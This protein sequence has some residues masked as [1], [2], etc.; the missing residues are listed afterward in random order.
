MPPGLYQIDA[1][2]YLP[3]ATFVA[4]DL[5]TQLTSQSY[6]V[7]VGQWFR[8][9][10]SGEDYP[11][12]VTW[13]C[14]ES[15][16]GDPGNEEYWGKVQQDMGEDQYETLREQAG[17]YVEFLIHLTP[18]TQEPPFPGF[19][20]IGCLQWSGRLLDKCPYGLYSEEII[21]DLC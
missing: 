7:P 3:S 4:Q 11:N 14:L 13:E 2:S 21:S 16:D 19:N 18:L 20:S 8:E 10:R 12:W 6:F 15:S 5:L 9:T 1:Y 17:K